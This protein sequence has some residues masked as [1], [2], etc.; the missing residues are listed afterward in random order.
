MSLIKQWRPTLAL[1]GRILID[2]DR[3]KG[4]HI[5]VEFCLMGLIS[6]ASD[7]NRKGYQPARFEEQKTDNRKACTGCT[8]CATVCPE[9]AIEVYREK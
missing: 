3:C 7:S 5:C 6:V 9:I 1:K 2:E 8:S 4:C